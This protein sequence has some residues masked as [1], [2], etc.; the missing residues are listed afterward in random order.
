MIKA[1]MFISFV[2]L[3]LIALF[4]IAYR[5]SPAS[6]L[7]VF[8]GWGFV[9]IWAMNNI[10]VEYMRYKGKKWQE[11]IRSSVNEMPYMKGKL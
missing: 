10:L 5:G 1:I 8:S 4:S 7:A 3:I 6:W 9:F 11:K 2:G